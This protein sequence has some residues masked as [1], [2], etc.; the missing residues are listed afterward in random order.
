[1]SERE[2]LLRHVVLQVVRKCPQC[3]QPFVGQDVRFLG[4]LDETWLFSLYCHTC[5]VLSI[6][7]LAVAP[8]QPGKD[9]GPVEARPINADD[10]LD[11]H[12]LL[13]QSPD[14]LRLLRVAS[15]SQE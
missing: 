11:M 4:Q 12:L 6:V 14:I 8:A 2:R 9:R 15:D 1:V 3:H 5:Q 13:E 10:V 7:G